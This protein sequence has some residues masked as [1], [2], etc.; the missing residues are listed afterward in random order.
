MTVIGLTGPTGAGKTTALRVLEDMGFVVDCDAL[1][2]ELLKT[3]E[4]LRKN[5]RDTFGDVFLPDGQ[6]DRP[7]LGRLVFGTKGI[8]QAQCHC[9][10][11]LPAVKSQIA[12]CPAG[13]W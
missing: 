1:Y 7:M 11:A 9:V 12:A 2:Y 4:D 6:L 13:G 5:L 8:G 3:D 10:P